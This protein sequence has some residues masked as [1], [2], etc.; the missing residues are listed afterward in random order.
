MDTVYLRHVRYNKMRLSGEL[1]GKVDALLDRSGKLGLELLEL[2][3][4]ERGEVTD[5]A[6]LLNTVALRDRG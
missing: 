5:G 2:L 4:L 3:G 1:G 6:D